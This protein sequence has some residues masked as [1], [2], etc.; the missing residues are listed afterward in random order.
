MNYRIVSDSG[1]NLKT[2]DSDI[3]YVSVPL[4]ISTEE[5]EFVDDDALQVGEMIAYLDGYKGKSGTACPGVGQWLEAFGDAEAVFCFT[6]TSALS[7]SC[8][9]ARLA[10][11]EYEEEHPGRHVCIVDSLSAGPEIKLLIEKVQELICQ[12]KTYETICKEIMEY[13]EHTGLLFS[14]ESLKNLANN[15]RISPAVAKIAGVLGIRVVGRAS[16]HGELEAMDKC[17]G[18]KK[19][20]P[21]IIKHMKEMGYAGGQARI[22]HCCNKP[23]AEKLKQILLEEYADAD[24]RIGETFGLCSFYAEQGGLLIGFERS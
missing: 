15:G 7:G 1:S 16:E 14:L 12:G 5:R 19:A 23:A 17:R 9:A 24:I 18:E 21:A 2:V 3:A 4:K 10:G 11:E 22:D 8:N 6:I 13:K 20:L